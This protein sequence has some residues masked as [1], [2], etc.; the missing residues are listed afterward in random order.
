MTT[1]NDPLRHWAGDHGV[2]AVVQNPSLLNM[3]YGH[4][5]N[6][7]QAYTEAHAWQFT[8]DS[9]SGIVSALNSIG[10]IDLEV[11]RLYHTPINRFEFMAVL[12]KR[13]VS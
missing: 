5:I 13:L 12:R 3:A 8:P 4:A 11:E 1:H 7:R 6:S 2:P 9:F 10:L